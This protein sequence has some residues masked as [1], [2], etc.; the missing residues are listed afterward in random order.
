[1]PRFQRTATVLLV[2]FGGAC[3]DT[4]A[5][6]GR[7]LFAENCT[8]CHGRDGKGR[9]P[10]TDHLKIA[11]GDLTRLAQRNGGTFDAEYVFRVIDGQVEVAEHRFMPMWGEVFEEQLTDYPHA[12]ERAVPFVRALTDYL[13][14]IQLDE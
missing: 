1:V 13:E 7:L 8:A 9:G 14:S 4:S 3:T 10:M 11:P 6:E 12:A 5:D 2:I